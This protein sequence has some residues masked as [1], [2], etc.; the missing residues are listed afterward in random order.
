ML[1]FVRKTLYGGKSP[2]RI[3]TWIATA[4][5]LDFFCFPPLYFVLLASSLLY[6]LH[7]G[8]LLSLAWWASAACLAN[9][10]LGSLYAVAHR[11]R[12]QAGFAFAF[13]FLSRHSLKLRVAHRHARSGQRCKDA[14][15]NRA[16]NHFLKSRWRNEP[17]ISTDK[18][19]CVQKI[20][21]VPEPWGVFKD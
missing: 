2:L 13:L 3:K 17:Q 8:N 14:V 19:A 11:D 6:L 10:M 4:F 9:V 21:I 12:I 7:G 1:W 18:S 16:S 15:V 5:L 20:L